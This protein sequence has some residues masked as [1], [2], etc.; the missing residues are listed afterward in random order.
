LR[1][2]LV[3]APGRIQRIDGRGKTT[4]TD[5]EA[6]RVAPGLRVGDTYGVR[7][8]Y[9]HATADQLARDRIAIAPRAR[10]YTRLGLAYGSPA[11]LGALG[12][13]VIGLLGLNARALAQPVPDRRLVALAQRLSAGARSEWDRVAG[14]ERYLLGGRFRY[15]TRVPKPGPQPLVDFLVRD[16]A[17]YCQQ[18]AGAAALLLRLEGVPAR[19]VAG[20]ATGVQAAPERY[21]VRDLDAHEWIEVYFPGYGWVPFNPTPGS[22]VATVASGLDP[23]RPPIRAAI[24]R[25]EL[26]T[27]TVIAA[28]A[29]VAAGGIVLGR[30]R[31]RRRSDALQELLE[32]IARRSGARLEP[33]STIHELRVALAQL[34]PRMAELAAETERARFAAGAPAPTGHPCV[35]LARALSGDLGPVR[36]LLVGVPALCRTNWR[37]ARSR[38]GPRSEAQQR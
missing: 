16:R 10:A 6:W 30:R 13:L 34:G 22:D 7:A 12:R 25:A 9:V 27:A 11:G 15:T 4:P 1:N 24:G 17:G 32:R 3:V 33:S 19:V 18:F 38:P 37:S 14:V 35:R 23:L 8:G 28:L 2:D 29:A 5:G 21:T 36:A 31:S 20:F 26:A